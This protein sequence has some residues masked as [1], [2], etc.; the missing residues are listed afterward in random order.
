MDLLQ[1]FFAAQN[2]KLTEEV[3]FAWTKIPDKQMDSVKNKPGGYSNR[4][5][6]NETIFGWGDDP[7]NVSS[8][9]TDKTV[10]WAQ[11]PEESEDMDSFRDGRGRGEW[12]KNTSERENKG[13]Q[14]I[15]QGD[16]GKEIGK[17]QK[18]EQKLQRR[19]RGTV[20]EENQPEHHVGWGSVSSPMETHKMQDL[21]QDT[22]GRSAAISPR[23]GQNDMWTAIDPGTDQKR[24]SSNDAWG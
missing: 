15:I 5:H 4:L 23:V 18:K 17:Q 12:K 13:K 14:D 3:P 16:D 2:K 11:S 7:S 10:K 8:A 22:W 21:A 19:G 20:G 1:S 9:A 6:D 24:N